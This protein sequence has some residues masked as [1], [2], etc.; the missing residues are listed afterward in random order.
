MIN[1]TH[2]K[3]SFHGAESMINQIALN[4]PL[5]GYLTA[6]YISNQRLQE[7][8]STASWF[9]KNYLSERYINY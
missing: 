5:Y 1:D 7:F 4:L 2:G 3:V 6:N 8:A 9:S